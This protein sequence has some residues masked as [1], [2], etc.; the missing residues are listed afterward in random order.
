[1]ER[2]NKEAAEFL[3]T[4]GDPFNNVLPIIPRYVFEPVPLAR[5]VDS[6]ATTLPF[7]TTLPY[8]EQEASKPGFPPRVLS[9][10][11]TISQV[12][13]P[14]IHRPTGLEIVSI[15]G[16]NGDRIDF[17]PPADPI[18]GTL[19][20]INSPVSRQVQKRES[21]NPPAAPLYTPLHVVP[22]YGFTKPPGQDPLT[23]QDG[24]QVQ[25]VKHP[26][27]VD[28]SDGKGRVLP[29]PRWWDEPPYNR[30]PVPTYDPRTHAYINGELVSWEF[31]SSIETLQRR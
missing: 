23:Y 14:K 7:C 27:L 6:S 13:S 15:V 29:Q 25:E 17:V 11:V 3:R 28:F 8:L 26:E 1:M 10:Q 21:A 12:G 22:R 31:L 9:T 20:F 24:K 30:P 19:P 18:N 5:R 2:G 16:D 4:D